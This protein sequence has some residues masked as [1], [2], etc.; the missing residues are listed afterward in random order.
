MWNT[1]RWRA[2]DVYGRVRTFAKLL[3]F[4][5]AVKLFQETLDEKGEAGEKLTE[6]AETVINVEAKKASD[7]KGEDGDEPVAASKLA[8]SKSKLKRD[9]SIKR[10]TCSRLN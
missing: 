1:T 6:L 7:E 8:A 9:F 4:D 2:T 5:D 10:D 3:G